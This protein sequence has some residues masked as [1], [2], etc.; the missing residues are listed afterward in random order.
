MDF[1][2]TLNFPRVGNYKYASFKEE[3][4][5][6]AEDFR[7]SYLRNHSKILQD[8][9][10]REVFLQKSMRDYQ[11]YF[12]GPK[13]RDDSMHY[14]RLGSLFSYVENAVFWN[15][16]DLLD[17]PSDD[18]EVKD[19]KVQRFT[20][21]GWAIDTFSKSELQELLNISVNQALINPYDRAGQPGR[22]KGHSILLK[23]IV[24][25]EGSIFK[26]AVDE[27][28]MKRFVTGAF[29]EE[30]SDY[31]FSPLMERIL[32]NYSSYFDAKETGAFLEVIEFRTAN[33][34]G[35]KS[36]KL[37]QVSPT[38][39]KQY[40]DFVK[41]IISEVSPSRV[42]FLLEPLKTYSQSARTE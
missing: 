8:A 23:D 28:A 15:I 12:H 22:Y 3:I 2:F 9:E 37:E 40:S 36:V 30:V 39:R 21:R 29:W 32:T 10:L 26:T 33:H 7:F 42:E 34:H 6:R 35:A 18:A 41:K 17:G 25:K 11:S 31:N 19:K 20:A 24:E 14:R 4:I 16:L 27:K 38:A 1:D 13:D 5:E